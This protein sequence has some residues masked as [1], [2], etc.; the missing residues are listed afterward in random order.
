[1]RNTGLIVLLLLQGC[2]AGEMR[3]LRPN[4]LALAPY[5]EAGS[6]SFV[7]SLM[8]EGNC[9]LF[10]DDDRTTRLLP[11]WPTGSKFEE[12][13]VT[14]HRPGKA[15]QRV[16]VGEE[17]LLDGQPSDWAKLTT[18]SLARFQHQCGA[19]PFYVTA[20]TPAN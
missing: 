1:M 19:R 11:I 8:Y 18:P 10:E 6:Q 14:F 20:I 17:I 5:Q 12:S 13:L 7:G 15:E 9:L 3:P 2:A 4:E 16:P